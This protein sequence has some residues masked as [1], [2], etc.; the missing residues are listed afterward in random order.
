MSLLTKAE[1]NKFFEDV[2]LFLSIA[3]LYVGSMILFALYEDDIL[4]APNSS[5]SS[6]HDANWTTAATTVATTAGPN[7]T[8]ST[9][10]VGG[11][12][13]PFPYIPVL[14]LTIVFPFI[15]THVLMK[16]ANRNLFLVYPC[17]GINILFGCFYLAIALIETTLFLL[18]LMPQVPF[19]L[20][21]IPLIIIFGGTFLAVVVLGAIFCRNLEVGRGAAFFCCA[22]ILGGL[23][24]PEIVFVSMKLDGWLDWRWNITFIP[25][26]I[27]DII[28]IF[29]GITMAQFHGR[30]LASDNVS[31]GDGTV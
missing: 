6:A 11:V 7:A 9:S 19:L 23:C 13:N 29:F 18:A 30:K 27:L 16:R 28:L 14:V 4:Q 17:S 12:Y 21:S 3:W 25:F 1:V 22:A 24:L 31:H 26:W 2:Y 8:N 10:Y 20:K 5:S 15:V